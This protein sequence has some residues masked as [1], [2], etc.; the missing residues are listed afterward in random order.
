M[1]RTLSKDNQ[2]VCRKRTFIERHMNKIEAWEKGKP[3]NFTVP[4]PN[5]QQT[6]K[7]FIKVSGKDYLGDYKVANTFVPG[8][9]R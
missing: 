4:N 8:K 5:K 3:V 1:A 7:P 2:R 9:G 6:N